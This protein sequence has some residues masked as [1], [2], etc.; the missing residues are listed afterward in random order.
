[1]LYMEYENSQSFNH[2]L[3]PGTF[4]REF[5]ELLNAF[6]DVKV[7]SNDDR[8]AYVRVGRQEL[9]YGSQRLVS[10]SEWGNVRRTFDGFKFLSRSENLDFDAF[11]TRPVIPSPDRFDSSDDEVTFAG[12]WATYR[13]EKGQS[14]ELYYLLLSNG[15]HVAKGSD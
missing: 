8:Y 9:L 12:A 14:T 15:N 2:D 10:P 6:V 1:R 7:F 3:D 13:P 11:L 4:D 5:G